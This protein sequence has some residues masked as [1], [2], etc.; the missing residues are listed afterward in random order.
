MNNA[1]QADAMDASVEAAEESTDAF[2]QAKQFLAER[3]IRRGEKC[4]AC[5]CDFTFLDVH[6]RCAECDSVNLCVKCFGEAAVV[7]T[8][9][10]THQYH[11]VEPQSFPVLHEDWMAEEE[12]NILDGVYQKGIHNWDAVAEFVP[13]KSKD[14]CRNHY[15]SAYLSSACAPLPDVTAKDK[16]SKRR[17]TETEKANGAPEEPVELTR[18]KATRS[19]TKSDVINPVSSKAPSAAEISGYMPLREEFAVEWDDDAELI[20]ADMEFKDDDEDRVQKLKILSIYNQKLEERSKRKEFVLQR[21]LYDFKQQQAIE[22]SLTKE[23]LDL[24]KSLKPFA[25]FHSTQQHEKLVSG[26]IEE[27]RLRKRIETLKSY[28]KMGIEVLPVEVIEH[29]EHVPREQQR[30]EREKRWLKRDRESGRTTITEEE[31]KMCSALH[32][33]PQHYDIM[34]HILVHKAAHAGCLKQGVANQPLKID[35]HKSGQMYDLF[36][37]ST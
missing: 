27:L 10:P 15:M 12:L 20:L 33:Q 7:G 16:Q 32:L 11:V 19:T 14:K 30:S 18:E 37:K 3:F 23:E 28:Q 13:T 24:L 17:K 21:R 9:Q 34:K 36:V 6:I 29:R 4:D 5:G 1:H 35:V 22:K 25:R 26:M 8:H 2:S 31:R